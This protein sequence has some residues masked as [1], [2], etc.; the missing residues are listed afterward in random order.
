MIFIIVY[1]LISMAILPLSRGAL[2][3]GK[4]QHDKREILENNRV[5]TNRII[6]RVGT[7]NYKSGLI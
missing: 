7:V 6:N 2:R 4:F 3:S 1:R 5:G